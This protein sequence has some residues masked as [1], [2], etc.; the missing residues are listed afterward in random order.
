MTDRPYGDGDGTF[1]A[2][3][4]VEGIQ[5]LVE[6][7]YDVMSTRDYARVIRDMH[8]ND[9]TISIDKLARF[10]C[11]WMGG[12]RRYKDKYGGI[13]IPPAHK[14][15]PIHDSERN[16]WLN[17]MQEALDRQPYPQSFKDYLIEQ[18]A[19][20]AGRIVN[21]RQKIEQLDE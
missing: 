7:F 20:P 6:D 21:L 12:P 2:A 8:P 9:L 18:L 11:G 5:R 16:A 13:A 19:V 10:L 4:G 1:R 14:H 17:C 15:L 3:G